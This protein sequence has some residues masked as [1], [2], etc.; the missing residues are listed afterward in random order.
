MKEIT[1]AAVRT[2]LEADETV[3]GESAKAV[4]AVR[5]GDL[6]RAETAE[7]P[8]AEPAPDGGGVGIL[9]GREVT[10]APSGE[11]AFSDRVAA[12]VTRRLVDTI[13]NEISA[14]LLANG[15]KIEP[16]RLAGLRFRQFKRFCAIMGERPN[17][18]PYRAA[19]A[20]IA[21]LPGYEGY[22]DPRS[23]LRYAAKHRLYWGRE[24]VPEGAD[25]A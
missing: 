10:P 16:C 7:R 12:A 2:L 4:M 20:A 19:K 9:P 6:G 22:T 18:T 13:R 11:S 24:L 17:E 3:D 5:D 21:E 25:E 1:K 23:L 15:R 8:A 14:L